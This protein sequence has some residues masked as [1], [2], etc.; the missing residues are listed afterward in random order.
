MLLHSGPPISTQSVVIDA[1]GKP[2][3]FHASLNGTG[4]KISAFIDPALKRKAS[5]EVSFETSPEALDWYLLD[6][7]HDSSPKRFSSESLAWFMTS[8][9][10]KNLKPHYKG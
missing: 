10:V 8:S 3:H 2:G 7:P 4:S 1:S 6:S 5:K 9:S